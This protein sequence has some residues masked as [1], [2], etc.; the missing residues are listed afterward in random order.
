MHNRYT[1]Y[2]TG[3]KAEAFL[4][5]N[6][7]TDCGAHPPHLWDPSTPLWYR[8]RGILTPGGKADEAEYSTRQ[9]AKINNEWKYRPQTP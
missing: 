3:R 6:I 7:E 5:Q 2:V 1:E 4:L 8:Y 9:G